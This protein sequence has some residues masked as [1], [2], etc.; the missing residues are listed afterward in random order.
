LKLTVPE[1]VAT[2]GEFSFWGLFWK[3]CDDWC[4][5]NDISRRKPSRHYTCS[6]HS[7]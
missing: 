3:V 5:T 2:R 1:L 7:L 6:L 4:H